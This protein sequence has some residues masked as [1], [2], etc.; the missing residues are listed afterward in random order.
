MNEINARTLETINMALAEL[1]ERPLTEN[2][3]FY[4]DTDFA[5]LMYVL[6][7]DRAAPIRIVIEYGLEIQVGPYGD[8]LSYGPGDP[9]IQ[10]DVHRL[11]LSTILV[12]ERPKTAR[13]TLVDPDGTVWRRYRTRMLWGKHDPN[14]LLDEYRPAF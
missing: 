4:K 10:E 5:M 7:V 13:I 9:S 8:V 6:D 11:L 14:D 2:A 12:D 3:K 1:G